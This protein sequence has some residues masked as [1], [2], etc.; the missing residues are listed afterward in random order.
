MSTLTTV[1]VRKEGENKE[2]IKS[3]HKKGQ[4][5][6]QAIQ[7][8]EEILNQSFLALQRQKKKTKQKNVLHIRNVLGKLFKL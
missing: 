4:A 2:K 6:T 5:E 1:T 3:K 8:I 7:E